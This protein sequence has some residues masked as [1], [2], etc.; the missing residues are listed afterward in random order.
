MILENNLCFHISIIKTK[1][2]PEWKWENDLDNKI[3][4]PLNEWKYT[5]IMHIGGNSYCGIM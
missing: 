1:Y 4:F 5:N 3:N 2:D